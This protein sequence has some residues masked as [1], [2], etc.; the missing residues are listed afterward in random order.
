MRREVVRA[1]RYE[2][3]E[4]RYP[5]GETSRP[6]KRTLKGTK[7]GLTSFVNRVCYAVTLE[8]GCFALPLLPLA[9]KCHVSDTKVDSFWDPAGL[10]IWWDDQFGWIVESIQGVGTSEVSTEVEEGRMAEDE[11]ESEEDGGQPTGIG[12]DYNEAVEGHVCADGSTCEGSVSDI[13][14]GDEPE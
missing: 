9:P 8:L 3:L 4:L 7:S 13:S 12:G 11:E 1:M 10:G 5:T 6:N 14:M 2:Q